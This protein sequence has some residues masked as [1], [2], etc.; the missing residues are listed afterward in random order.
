MNRSDWIGLGSSIGLHLLLLLLFSAL[1]AT[2]PHPRQLGYVEVEFGDF[3]QGRPVEAVEEPQE[4]AAPEPTEPESE[5]EPEPE[6][7]PEEPQQVQEQ[8]VDLPEETEPSE[9]EDVPPAE[10]ET[11]PP[12][13]DEEE[14]QE[15]ETED[16]E[17]N[18]RNGAE[19]GDPGE[20]TAE[21]KTAP[22]NIEGLD[23]DPVYAPIPQYAEKVNARIRVRITVDPQ[24]RI[25]QRI[26]L[27]KGN[28]A[29]EESVMETLQRWRFNALPPGAPQESQTGII[30]FTFRLE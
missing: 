2:R 16:Q 29:L 19:E 27:L 1:T 7:E 30:T 22:Y 18:A 14:P 9:T 4:E 26:P 21:Q 25:T 6:S 11:V 24:G 8:P 13:A 17:A 3:A 5:P 28:P 20:G 12:Q 10:E 23:R 15:Q